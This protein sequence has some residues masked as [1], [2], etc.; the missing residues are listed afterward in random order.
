[1]LYYYKKEK[2][3]FVRIAQNS[4]LDPEKSQVIIAIRKHVNEFYVDTLNKR[5]IEAF[6]KVTH[7]EYYKRFAEDFDNT[8]CMQSI[9][10]LFSYFFSYIKKVEQS[11][12]W[13]K[14]PI[15]PMGIISF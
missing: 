14:Y 4:P 7:E 6:L 10:K 12:V 11:S 1:M 5:A 8:R 15:I 2:N 9:R 3:A 13:A